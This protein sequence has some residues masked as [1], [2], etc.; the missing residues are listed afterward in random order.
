MIHQLPGR[1]ICRP[2]LGSRPVEVLVDCGFA[3]IQFHC[4]AAIQTFYKEAA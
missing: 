1:A 4:P 3:E 2:E